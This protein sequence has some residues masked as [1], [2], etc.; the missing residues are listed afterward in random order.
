[1]TGTTGVLA[2]TLTPAAESDE[3]IATNS[4]LAADGAD[5]AFDLTFIFRSLVFHSQRTELKSVPP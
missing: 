1:V 5:G 4:R 2:G 3:S